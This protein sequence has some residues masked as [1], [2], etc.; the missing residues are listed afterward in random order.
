MDVPEIWDKLTA[1]VEE[2]I[3]AEL[4]R[5]KARVKTAFLARMGTP[6]LMTFSGLMESILVAN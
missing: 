6:Y 2:L 5:N 4:P 1:V 3:A